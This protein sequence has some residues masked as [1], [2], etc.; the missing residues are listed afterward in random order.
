LHLTIEVS[1]LS[2]RRDLP[3]LNYIV[4]TSIAG[5][6]SELRNQD[7]VNFALKP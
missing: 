2:S 7:A 3:P 1:S 5:D 6:K 4:E